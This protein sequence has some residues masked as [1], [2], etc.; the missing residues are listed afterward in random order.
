MFLQKRWL[1]P[2]WARLAWWAVVFSGC[3]LGAALLIKQFF[4]PAA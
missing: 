1:A 4:L 3:W 2:P